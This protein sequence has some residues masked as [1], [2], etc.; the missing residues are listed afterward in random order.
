MP[1]AVEAWSLNYWM[2]REV[3]SAFFFLLHMP[4]TFMLSKVVKKAWA[5]I[6]PFNIYLWSSI[7]SIHCVRASKS[8]SVRFSLHMYKMRTITPISRLAQ[9]V[10]KGEDAKTWRVLMSFKLCPFP[11]PP[12]IPQSGPATADYFTSLL[13]CWGG[14]EGGASQM[15]TP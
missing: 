1:P 7:P 4:F 11:P 5:F 6:L 13:Q 2:A 8:I 14:K 9:N 10:Q 15:L 12:P 3:L